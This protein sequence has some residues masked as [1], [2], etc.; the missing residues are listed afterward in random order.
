VRVIEINPGHSAGSGEPAREEEKGLSSASLEYQSAVPFVSREWKARRTALLV[1]ARRAFLYA[2]LLHSGTCRSAFRR[3]RNFYFII[4]AAR[5]TTATLTMT[6]TTLRSRRPARARALFMEPA[7]DRQVP[8]RDWFRLD[9]TERLRLHSTYTVRTRVLC[10]YAP[11]G[12]HPE[13]KPRAHA[14]GGRP[15]PVHRSV[16]RSRCVSAFISLTHYFQGDR[17]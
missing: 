12:Y 16:R 5:T 15:P 2:F 9:L 3:G 4:T 17:N 13:V 10:I 11:P 1:N 8:T 14:H 6:R 7:T